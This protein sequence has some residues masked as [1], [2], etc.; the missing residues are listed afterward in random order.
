MKVLHVMPYIPDLTS[1][2]LVRDYNII[3]NLS[4]MN[5]CS[6]L[7]CNYESSEQLTSL[8]LLENQLNIKI[9]SMRT[10]DLSLLQKTMCV[11]T[12]RMF[13]QVVRFNKESNISFISSILQKQDFDI[14]H[15][16]HSVEAAPVIKACKKSNFRGCKILTLHN[17]DHLNFARLTALQESNLMKFAYKRVSPE[18]KKFELKTIQEFD[19]IF[20]V[21]ENDRDIYI[22]EGI[23]EDKLNVIPNGVDCLAFNPNAFNHDISLQHPNII[24]M[25]KLSYL[26]NSSGLKTYLENVHPLVKRKIPE[27]KFYVIG[28][29]CPNWLLE[30]SKSD[31]SLVIIGF[32]EDVKPYILNADVCIAPLTS[33]SGTRLKILEYMAMKKPVVSTSIGA[34]GLEIINGKNILIADQW[35]EFAEKIIILLENETFAKNIGNN[36]RILVEKLY[37][38]NK[39][40]EKQ[41]KVYRAISAKL[42]D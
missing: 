21:S 23:P 16:Q 1:G 19:H 8:D 35:D 29:D 13:P 10:T 30:Y 12:K 11:L 15:A 36:A 32:V 5:V 33:G 14:I 41:E 22:S 25:G 20:V 24:F 31:S 17:V 2:A 42:C 7:V 39:I 28:K 6:H 3:K 9:Y 26:P 18:Y 38:W 37:D 40:V 27:I 4:Q 34:E